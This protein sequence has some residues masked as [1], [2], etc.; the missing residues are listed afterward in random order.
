MRQPIVVALAGLA[1]FGAATTAQA[2]ERD[3]IA[4]L[5]GTGTPQSGVTRSILG[6]QA[7]LFGVSVPFSA[8]TAQLSPDLGRVTLDGDF[9]RISRDGSSFQSFAVTLVERIPMGRADSREEAASKPYFGIGVGLSRVQSKVKLTF[10]NGDETV[11]TTLSNAKLRLAYKV[12]AGIH[13]GNN[14]FVEVGYRSQGKALNL[15]GDTLGAGIGVR[16]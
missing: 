14:A 15:S 1:A 16:F 13:I 6:R 5:V 2:Q 11:T 10:T 8:A 4:V 7:S 9:V 12:V 3:K